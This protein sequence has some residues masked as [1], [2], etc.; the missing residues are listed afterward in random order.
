MRKVLLMERVMD[1]TRLAV[2]EDG[3]L[4]EL[5]HQRPNDDNLSGNIYLGRVENVLPGMNAAFVDFGMEKNGFLA[6]S[7]IR[8]FAQGDRTLAGMLG[9]ARIEKLVRPGQQLLVQAI[10]AEP[11]AKG[12]RLSCH[13]TLPGRSMV[14]LAGIQYVGVSRKIKGEDERARLRGIG[15]SLTKGGA[16]GVILRTAA[17]GMDAA[18]LRSEF[19]A[20]KTRWAEIQRR[21]EYTAGPKLIHDDNDLALHAVRDMLAEDVEA[22]WADDEVCYERLRALAGSMVPALQ[23]RIQRHTGD[24]PLF[25]LYRVDAQADKALQRY[26]WLKSGGSLVIEET[27]ALTVVDVNT[28]KNIGKRDADDTILAVNCE[29]ARELMRQLRLRDI[30][31]MIVVDFI[32]MQRQADRDALMTVLRECAAGDRNR[33]RVVDITALGLVELTR[34][35]ARQS[36]SKQ[37]THTCP[38]CDGNGVVPAHEATAR[39]ALRELWRR[40]RGGDDTALRLE[41]AAGVCCWIRRIGIP[42]GGRLELSPSD[43][44]GSGAYRF[45]PIQSEN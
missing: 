45:T 27:E 41:A 25:D 29:A 26:V 1:Q 23:D 34:K 14:L 3:Q 19:A 40:R 13:I 33:T 35:R 38:D 44:L 16:D 8:L 30:G 42:D 39:R 37:L 21:G 28:G 36:L 7:D 24:T 18:Q 32:N 4:C 31:G 5:I 43:A 2:V 6:A 15:L 17:Q 22:L 10:R 20:L 11:G 12:A 9:K